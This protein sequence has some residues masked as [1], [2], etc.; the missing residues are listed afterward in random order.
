MKG[1]IVKYDGPETLHRDLAQ[2]SGLPS[3]VCDRV[4]QAPHNAEGH[5]PG[6]GESLVSPS[7]TDGLCVPD[8]G[9]WSMAEFVA[10]IS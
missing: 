8:K 6:L 3:F 10:P 1:A 4:M 5:L 9:R 2:G 7:G